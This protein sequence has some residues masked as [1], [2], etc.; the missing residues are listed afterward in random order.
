VTEPT[1]PPSGGSP[2]NVSGDK[3]GEA[4]IHR[5]ID[6]ENDLLVMR[7]DFASLFAAYLDHVRRWESEPDGLSQTFMRQ[8][9]GAAILHLSAR[10][11]GETVGFTINVHQPATNVFLTGDNTEKTIVGRVFTED[12]KPSDHS[13]MFVQS[14]R[15]GAP[16]VQSAVEVEGLDILQMFEQYY[17]RSEQTSARFLEID[18]THFVML[19]ALPEADDDW[20]RGLSRDEA[21][22]VAGDELKPLG[23]SVFRFRCGCNPDR[24]MEL[25]R[26]LFAKE[27]EELF[28]RDEGVEILCPRCGRRWWVDRA[29]FD[30]AG[31]AESGEAERSGE[32]SETERGGH[33]PGAGG[34]A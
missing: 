18:D 12:V 33:S 5:H 31:D 15:L 1:P 20:L 24:M 19:L 21:L 29:E 27:P 34:G 28:R 11:D 8:G 9:L 3:L 23:Q 4:T 7:G 30:A 17:D 26:G 10:P 16:P 13:R 32:E 6:R 25:V 2:D 22:G 14:S